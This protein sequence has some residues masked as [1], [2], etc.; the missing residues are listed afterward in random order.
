M[1]ILL[2]SHDT[3]GLG[4]I[5][6]TL[7]LAG[8]MAGEGRNV[9][10]ITGSPVAGK[11]DYPKGIDYVRVP[12]MTKHGNDVYR[13]TSISLRPKKAL[14]IRQNIILATARTFKPA[15]FLVDKA[16]L[17]LG[18]EVL[19]TLRWLNRYM[20]KTRAVL[21]LRDI[22]DSSESTIR[23]WTD[24]KIYQVM[25]QLY[26]EIWV[27]GEREI[28]DPIS[29]YAIPSAI[30]GKMHFTGYIPRHFPSR[31]SRPRIRQTMGIAP[32]EKFVLL[33]TGGGGDGGK[34]IDTYLRML[35]NRPEPDLRSMIITGPFMA[36]D[37]YD[38]LAARARHVKA[39]IC[40]FYRK[41]EKA[42]LAADC[43]VSMGG[44]NTCCEIICAARPSLVIPRSIPREEQLIRAR[45][46]AGRGLL[47]YIPWEDVD[48]EG[49]RDKVHRLLACGEEY[50]ER[51][52]AFPMTAYDV[53][54]SRMA[55][56]GEQS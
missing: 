13:P 38:E 48:P 34:V 2:Y 46:F 39:R 29:E 31:R 23:D 47:E 55:A 49:I 25:D 26:S 16:P 36:E 7:A 43:I 6:R 5:R 54:G 4:H 20:P 45:I 30:A 17:G 28:Y 9:I 3:Y 32:H 56:F 24:K 12:G 10:I 15:L 37:E 33:T 1:N 52:R 41:I 8:N 21:G 19:P 40:K 27:Y 14:A 42:I 50:E 35:E 22:M 18:K 11:F 44:Y 53:I 51:L